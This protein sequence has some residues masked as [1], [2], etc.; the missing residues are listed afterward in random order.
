[1]GFEREFR[2]QMVMSD[3]KGRDREILQ[4]IREDDAREARARAQ[5]GHMIT[6]VVTSRSVGRDVQ[7]TAEK[8]RMQRE[9]LADQ[10]AR[11]MGDRDRRTMIDGFDDFTDGMGNAA[12][13]DSDY[14][15]G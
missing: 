13:R 2:E 4:D 6:H 15:L 8:A 5:L 11:S 12:R 3:D 7:S 14:G 9:N 10:A 1:M